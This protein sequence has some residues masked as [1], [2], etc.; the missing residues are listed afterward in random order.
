MLNSGAL[1]VV[2]GLVLVYF[3]LSTL[4]SLFQEIIEAFIGRRADYLEAG[5]ADLV[6][7]TLSRALFA[8][9]S[10]QALASDKGPPG[11]ASWV[12]KLLSSP[13]RW[14]RQLRRS[15]A[16]R[17]RPSYIATSTFSKNLLSVFADGSARLAKKVDENAL[18]LEVNTVLG[19][20]EG[21]TF[22]IQI[23]DE[24]MA[25]TLSPGGDATWSVDRHQ[26]NTRAAIHQRGAGITGVRDPLTTDELLIR[27][28]ALLASIPEGSVRIRLTTLLHDA[29]R[30][31]DTWRKSLED[32]FDEK[33][34]RVSGWYKR[35]TK[36]WLFLI[37][38]VLVFVMNADTVSIA[39]SLWTNQTLRDSVVNASSQ[40]IQPNP[41]PSA[42]SG[43]SSGSA[44]TEEPCPVPAPTPVPSASPPPRNSLQC[45]EQSE[46]AL[47]GLGLPIG[48]PTL[49]WK[50]WK[51]LPDDARVPHNATEAW[52]KLA[53][54]VLTALALT[55][56]APFWFDLLNRV[57]NLRSS[58]GAPKTGAGDRT[59]SGGTPMPGTEAAAAPALDTAGGADAGSDSP[60]GTQHGR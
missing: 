34:T 9:P 30:N 39:R 4:C 35:R 28:D 32:W 26:D 15:D 20:P 40:F 22:K 42:S 37:G 12:S 13:A 54:L 48:W 59:P 5:I 41:T 10:T 21:G 47:K 36:L 3:L 58:G 2:I 60:P 31:L 16:Q 19:F 29:G 8:H 33:M 44:N 57:A 7:P 18:T 14:V 11:L 17:S 27:V 46:N 45:L 6:G 51:D 49:N 55:L 24:I 52:L 43:G 53:G 56:G 38:I 23:D 25:A 50:T 1:G